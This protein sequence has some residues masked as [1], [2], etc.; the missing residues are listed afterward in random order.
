M[1]G[2]A[3]LT[4][5]Q[6]LTRPDL[7]NDTGQIYQGPVVL[8]TDAL[9]YSAAD[10]FAGG[11]QDH[12]IG[13]VIGL[14]PNTGGG[15]ANV[16]SHGRLLREIPSASLMLSHLPAGASMALAVRR[17]SRVGKN[18]GQ[19][20]EDVGVIADVLHER[21]LADTMWHS[22]DLLRF[23]CGVLAG[24]T[25]YRIEVQPPEAAPDGVHVTLT[26]RNIGLLDFFL[27][28]NK[29]LSA[30]VTPGLAQ[31]FIVPLPANDLNPLRLT[32]KGFVALDGAG[33]LPAAVAVSTLSLGQHAT[34]GMLRTFR[35]P[36]PVRR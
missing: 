18:E 28:G 3:R 13:T 1:P 33:Q 14:D 25:V 35:A 36:L 31:S 30:G 10:I 17:S 26:T 16:W 21:S 7:A 23:A 19:P 5:G 4:S 2:G 9:T 6:P 22:P 29:V 20:L 15:G 8:L 24:S 27:D 11:F 12:R 34:M 32:I